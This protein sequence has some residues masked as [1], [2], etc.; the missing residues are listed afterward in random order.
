MR[1][2][3]DFARNLSKSGSGRTFD[4]LDYICGLIKLHASFGDTN[5]DY[6]SYVTDEMTKELK[7][8]GYFV[9]EYDVDHFYISWGC[10]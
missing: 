6:G 8:M 9:K 5:I 1:I 7:E 2:K 3:A 4:H 10:E